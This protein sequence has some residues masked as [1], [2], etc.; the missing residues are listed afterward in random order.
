LPAS[1]AFFASSMKAANLLW[2]MFSAALGEGG[3]T[4]PGGA[5]LGGS[6]FRTGLVEVNWLSAGG[7]AGGVIGAAAAAASDG[8]GGP[9]VADGVEEVVETDDGAINGGAG[10]GVDEG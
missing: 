2:T 4:T 3:A 8:I 6:R 1:I 7:F 9:S 10:G 5:L